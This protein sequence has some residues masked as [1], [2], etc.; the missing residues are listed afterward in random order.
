[1]FG[2][3]GSSL[4]SLVAVSRGYSLVAV[5]RFLIAVNSVD[6]EHRLQAYELQ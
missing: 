3:P 6:A 2:C 1:M 5:G 4:L